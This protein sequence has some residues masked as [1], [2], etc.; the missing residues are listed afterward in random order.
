MSD[1]A[2][3]NQPDEM[4]PLELQAVGQHDMLR[5]CVSLLLD[6]GMFTAAKL[7]WAAALTGEH[8]RKQ[9]QMNWPSMQRHDLRVLPD[10]LPLGCRC[11]LCARQLP[12]FTH[13]YCSDFCASIATLKPDP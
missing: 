1:E 5:A 8:I 9:V 11:R 6:E 2:R 4:G 12:D 10:D 3:W 7:L 13:V